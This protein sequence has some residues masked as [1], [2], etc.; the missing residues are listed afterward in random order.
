MIGEPD[1][2]VVKKGQQLLT[3]TL[4]YD[5]NRIMGALAFASNQEIDISA[6][7]DA[8]HSIYSEL[9][10][11]YFLQ[12]GLVPA[13]IQMLRQPDLTRHTVVRQIIARR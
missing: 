12:I 4:Q 9:L 2:S 8:F 10:L 6:Y 1:S 5:R 11:T 13:L 3:D 7:I